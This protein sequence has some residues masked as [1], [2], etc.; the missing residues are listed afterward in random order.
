[1]DALIF[2]YSLHNYI[3]QVILWLAARPQSIDS[4]IELDSLSMLDILKASTETYN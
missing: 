3:T 2:A 4:T 1:M